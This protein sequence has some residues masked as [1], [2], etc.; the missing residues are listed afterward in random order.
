MRRR[1]MLTSAAALC[2]AACG[3]QQ[4]EQIQPGMN[5]AQVEAIMG[6]PV[7]YIREGNAELLSWPNRLMS[8]WSWDRADYH[9][10]LT[11]GRVTAYG[12]GQIRQVQSPVGITWVILSRA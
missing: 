2:A 11:D 6:R 1:T 12:T 8:G 4:M 10:V 5:R 3:N 9:A 7:G